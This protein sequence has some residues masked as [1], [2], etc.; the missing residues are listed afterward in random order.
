MSPRREIFWAELPGTDLEER[1]NS[2][3]LLL[4]IS[5]LRSLVAMGIRVGL[6]LEA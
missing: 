3:L 2:P 4:G 5:A 1:T 6:E